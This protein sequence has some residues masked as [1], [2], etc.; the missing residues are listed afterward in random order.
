MKKV[1]ILFS[2]WYNAPNGAASFIKSFVDNIEYFQQKINLTVYAKENIV[3]KNFSD[4]NN[5]KKI[6]KLRNYIHQILK[7]STLLSLMYK[8]Y[9]EERHMRT[10]VKHFVDDLDG[11]D[12]IH[13]QELDTAYYLFKYIP[14]LKSKVYLTLHSNGED[15]SMLFSQKPA[16]NNWLGRKYLYHKMNSVINRV[17]KIGFVSKNSMDTFSKNHPLFEKNKLFY[18]H[19]GIAETN[20]NSAKFDS[21]IINFICVG[22]LSKRKNQEALINA[23]LL[24]TKDEISKIKLTLVGDGTIREHLQNL[25]IKYNLNN[26]TFVGNTKNVDHYLNDADV[27]ILPSIDEGLPISIIEA[28]RAGLPIIGS[29]VAGIPEQIIDGVTGFIIEP[30]PISIS[31]AY[32]Q[33]LACSKEQLK[34]MGIESYNYYKLKF[35]L[36]GMFDNYINLYNE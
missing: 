2:G 22:T 21:D 14:T 17:D 18:V 5:I 16:L 19:N 12:I 35:T 8:H 33:I 11:Y 29:N 24:L 3:Y 7:H 23:L 4:S 30:D 10:I 25:T 6:N 13:C 34:I 32:K 28:M 15:F 1:C 20:I 26:V 36:N 31:N 9:I 27:F